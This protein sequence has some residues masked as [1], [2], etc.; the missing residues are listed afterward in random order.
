MKTDIMELKK[1]WR[2]GNTRIVGMGY[3]EIEERTG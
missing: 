3:L 1:D 2:G